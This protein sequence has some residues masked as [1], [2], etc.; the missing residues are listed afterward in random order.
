[1]EKQSIDKI[2]Q[3]RVDRL[4]KIIGDEKNMIQKKIMQIENDL[5]SSS[6]HQNMKK[7]TKTT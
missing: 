1:M 3:N 7:K 2:I 6:T 4:Q 5:L